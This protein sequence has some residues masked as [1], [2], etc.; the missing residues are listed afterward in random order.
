MPN[1]SLR[2]VKESFNVIS[3]AIGNVLMLF[4]KNAQTLLFRSHLLHLLT[5][6]LIVIP[7]CLNFCGCPS[8]VTL[9]RHQFYHY[10]TLVL[11]T[12]LSL[13]YVWLLLSRH[14]HFYF[15]LLKVANTSIICSCNNIVSFH[16]FGV[17]DNRFLTT[18]S[19]STF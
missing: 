12:F 10:L 5:E 9:R 15:T 7:T 4:V 3:I 16:T 13:G 14:S 17:G 19:N 6:A 11:I 1:R 2:L 8:T 18:F